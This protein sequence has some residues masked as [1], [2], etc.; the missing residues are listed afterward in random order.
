MVYSRIQAVLLPAISSD[1]VSQRPTCMTV[2]CTH[3][4]SSCPGFVQAFQVYRII[5]TLHRRRPLPLHAPTGA[6]VPPPREQRPGRICDNSARRC[7]YT[8]SMDPGEGL[9]SPG[10]TMTLQPGRPRS[11][12]PNV[13]QNIHA[14]LAPPTSA[15]APRPEASQAARPRLGGV[16][17]AAAEPHADA[18]DLTP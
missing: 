16:T 18:P 2:R 11:P 7:R 8:V 13:S 5:V 9:P 10:S 12:Q 1:R 14:S 4:V 17:V 6:A 3:P 15:N